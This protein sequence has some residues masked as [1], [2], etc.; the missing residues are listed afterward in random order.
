MLHRSARANPGETALV[1]GAA[2]GVG[3]ALL[4]LA[5]LHGVEAQGTASVGKLK[6]VEGLGGHAI[7]YKHFD[8][9][10]VIRRSFRG[11]VDMAFD[12]IGGWNLL[13]S[14]RA[15]APCSSPTGCCRPSPAGGGTSGGCS[16]ARR[17]GRRCTR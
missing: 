4:Q 3:T 11:G 8:F 16:P 10:Q 1:H 13:R 9:L 5:R 15:L 7:D 12:G 6:T 14:W 2:G 17:G